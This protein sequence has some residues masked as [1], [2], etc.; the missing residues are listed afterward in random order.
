[1]NNISFFC[2]GGGLYG[3][4]HVTRCLA[5][6]EEFAANG[7]G[8]E[9]V[10]N[11]TAEIGLAFPY[12][13]QIAPSLWADK[14]AGKTCVIDSYA[15]GAEDIER[16]WRSADAVLW[17]DDENLR[18][19]PGGTV[20]NPS[21]FGDELAYVNPGVKHLLGADYIILRKAFR[22]QVVKTVNKEINELTV[23][24][25][26]TDAKNMLPVITE[27]LSGFD[28]KKNIIGVST[29]RLSAE[30]M[31]DLF[32]QS[33]LV[34]SAGGQTVNELIQL[35]TPAILIE[36]ARNQR[37]NIK[38]AVEKG[39]AVTCDIQSI[40]DEV[41]KMDHDTRR[42]LVDNMG[43]YDFSNGVKNIKTGLSIS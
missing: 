38:A 11:G 6:A 8:V 20:V 10:I 18:P 24:M 4:G 32:L 37:N 13:N 14:A 39:L 2:D 33:D 5:L 9:F 12:Q 22:R 17:I 30:Q 40:A 34:I 43:K 3:M 29:P 35:N 28:C 23:I 19:Y 31:A 41:I 36:A 25:G 1:M 26:G 27:K 15:I 21:L 7:C 42:Q 16:V